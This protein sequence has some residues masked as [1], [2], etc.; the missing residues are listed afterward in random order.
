MTPELPDRPFDSAHLHGAVGHAND[1][2]RH[3]PGTRQRRG[4][5][6]LFA[7]RR[8]A[9]DA[10]PDLRLRGRGRPDRDAVQ[11]RSAAERLTDGSGCSSGTSTSQTGRAA[12]GRADS[13]RR[14][15]RLGDVVA[16][17]A[18]WSPDGESIVFARRR[19]VVHGW[20]RRHRG[21]E[22][23]DCARPR[24]LA[25]MVA[26]RVA[27]AFH[28]PQS[29]EDSSSLWD[30]S[31]EGRDMRPLPAAAANRTMTV[32]AIGL[33][34]DGISSSEDTGTNGR[35]SGPSAKNRS[36]RRQ[37]RRAHAP[38]HGPSALSVSRPEPGRPPAARDRHPAARRNSAVRPRRAQVRALSGPDWAGWFAFSRDGA[39]VADVEFRAKGYTLWRSRVDGSERLQLTERPLQLLLPRWSPDG[40]RIAFMGQ[41]RGRPWK[42][43]V[44][45]ADGGEPKPIMD[46]DRDEADPNWAPDGQSLM[47]G[48]PPGLPGRAFRAESDSG[49]R[50]R[51]RKRC[52]CCPARMDCSHRAGRPVDATLRRCP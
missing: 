24:P 36:L 28:R 48:R 10:R 3:L 38:D 5:D 6:L 51:D 13:W 41:A 20:E 49:S 23:R 2:G 19:G 31:A 47:F 52:Q 50:P 39:W 45:A 12:V 4:P 27:L 37:E 46:G 25:P 1:L 34:T 42:I 40:K 29:T 17:D 44:V 15:R 32:A 9:L 7:D 35:T 30:V 21:P 14:L 18:A 16:H 26:G 33:R 22:A 11:G 43:Y 8:R